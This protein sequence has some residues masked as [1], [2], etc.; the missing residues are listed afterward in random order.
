MV[1]TAFAADQYLELEPPKTLTGRGYGYNSVSREFVLRQCVQVGA[2]VVDGSG[3]SGDE[4]K[5]SSVV[6]N[7]Q[8]ADEMNLAV[9][10]K[11][12]ASMGLVS[13]NA[14]SKVD[15]FQSTKTNFN[16]HTILA[17]YHNVEPMKF[18]AGD[19]NLKPEYLAM[20]GTPAFRQQCGDYV[21]IGEQKGRWFFGT[22]QLSVRDTATESK[23]AASGVIGVE[24]ATMN[25]EVGVST[26]NKLKQAS[27]TQDLEIHVTSSGSNSASL[28]VDQFLQQVQSFPGQNGPKQTFKL[29]AVPY[30]DIVA[31]WPVGNP[32]APITSEQK[33]TKLAEA[34]WGL[35]ALIDDSDFM[36][37]NAKLFALGTTPAK[38]DA[39]VAFIKARRTYYQTQLADMRNRARDCDVDWAG[40]PACESLYNTWKDFEDFVVGE[41]DQFPMRYVSECYAS[42]DVGDNIQTKLRTALATTNGQFSNTKGDREMGGGPVNFSANLTF[43]SDH[44][45]GDPLDTRKLLSTL[46]IRME[47]SKADHTTFETTLKTPVFDLA[48]PTP[49]ETL[50]QCSYKGTGVKA[51]TVSPDPAVCAGLKLI[52]KKAYEDCVEGMQ[53]LKYHGM[54]SGKT[55]E[56]PRTETFNKNS[57]GVLTSMKC[58]VDSNASNDT[59]MIGC[60]SIDLRSV[61]LDLV[62]RQDVVADKWVAPKQIDVK[63]LKPAIK[64]SMQRSNALRKVMTSKSGFAAKASRCA[65]G[66][67][68][69]AGQCLPKLKKSR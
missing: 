36:I 53:N 7:S 38:R 35:T 10:T 43:K 59:S 33:L 3:A 18:T 51:E 8:L 67:V 17:K 42:R 9:N 16:T 13:A 23:L 27:S 60:Q 49:G 11:F 28:S 69:V 22:V 39:R 14:S 52:N 30:E 12:S 2:A 1:P 58:T 40:K 31:N 64:P 45:G 6:S 25:A 46:K 4:F 41:Y 56:D 19:I 61:P 29:M 44:T 47:E 15:F 32:L 63:K 5:F 55:G 21:L 37:Q 62:N 34:A 24:Y 68:S 65:E 50:A 26:I 57:R 54:L 48:G 66:L 20:I